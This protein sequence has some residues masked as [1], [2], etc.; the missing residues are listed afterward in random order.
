[1]KF[2]PQR[3]HFLYIF[4]RFFVTFGL[5]VLMV[6]FF[7]ITGEW[8]VLMNYITLPIIAVIGPVARILDYLFTYYSISDE[9][10]FINKGILKKKNTE[11]PLSTI[12]NVDYSQ[13]VILQLA[14]AYTIT[15][16]TAA[17]ISAQNRSKVKLTLKGEDA[18]R[19]KAL[20]LADKQATAGEGPVE[21]RE[22]PLERSVPQGEILSVTHA[23][24]K[25]IILMGI[26]EA[27]LA[28]LAQLFSIV[29]VVITF[30]SMLFMGRQ[31]DGEELI[32][33]QILQISGVALIVL[34]VL[35]VYAMGFIVGVLKAMLKYYNFRITNRKDSIF[36]EYGLLTKKTHT[37]M[38]K[39]VSG[40]QFKQP[41]LM[42]LFKC[43]VL[44]VFAVGYGNNPEEGDVT[45][46]LFPYLKAS[47]LDNFIAHH[48][49]GMGRGEEM[50]KAEKRSLRYFF[51]APRFFVAIYVLAL[52]I[53]A[54]FLPVAVPGTAALFFDL[55]WIIGGVIFLMVIGSIL[56]EYRNTGIF[57][58]ENCTGLSSGG[59]TKNRT[60]LYTH[61]IESLTGSG[62]VFKRRKGILT[63]N[64]GIW[65]SKL[66]ASHKVRNLEASAL[67]NVKSHI[68]Y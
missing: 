23:S 46:I 66:N 63:I 3:G 52:G 47:A 48:L 25:E 8:R 51:I 53:F 35:V 2:G 10:L 7:L 17:T 41:L 58:N 50:V 27:K 42:R 34:V 65:G 68:V 32:M 62:S 9:A 43:G 44:H 11:I 14:N 19:V 37:L 56:L 36:I 40:V 61:M 26:M 21:A 38:K 30:G 16:D 54:N 67:E 4:E 12:T 57:A 33:D 55:G 31:V 45:S 5:L 39:K 22:T 64:V 15:V 24:P 60:F 6:A 18:Q 59:Y 29:V 13:G 20:L 28:V 49:P 1:M